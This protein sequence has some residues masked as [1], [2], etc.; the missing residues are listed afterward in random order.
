MGVGLEMFSG[1]KRQRGPEVLFHDL[2]RSAARN[3]RRAGIDRSVIKRIGGWK[4]EAMFLRYNII[5][6]RDFVEA[7]RKMES[8][9]AQE[10]SPGA[11]ST[12]SS[13]VAEKSLPGS[14]PADSGNLLR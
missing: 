3:M 5:D 13:T 12:E 7:A 11:I 8:Y 4:T 9:R 2:R 10:C 6:E 1:C 14:P